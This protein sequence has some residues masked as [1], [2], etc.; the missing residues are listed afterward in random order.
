MN[1]WGKIVSSVK[2]AASVA[3]NVLHIGEH[4]FMEVEPFAA[5]T[6][7]LCGLPEVAGILNSV[8]KVV[9]ETE[10]NLAS[11]PGATK[12][13]VAQ[14]AMSAAIPLLNIGL[15]AVGKTID[16]DAV[17]SAT[18]DAIN[19]VV[20]ENNAQMLLEGM[21][22]EFSA[23]GKVPDLSAIARAS[24]AVSNAKSEVF[25]AGAT[26]QAAIKSI[27]SVNATAPVSVTQ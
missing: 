15:G 19:A 23:S 21:I 9:Q 5:T 25:K 3:G 7:K 14:T 4:V 17:A 18:T 1:L 27:G 10:A 2:N 22:K 16:A 6:F 11:H 12:L 26:I 13:A 24:L 8:Y 20:A